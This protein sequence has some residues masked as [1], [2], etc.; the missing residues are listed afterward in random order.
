MRHFVLTCD[1]V[2]VKRDER[3]QIQSVGL[4]RAHEL[5]AK[6]AANE[7]KFIL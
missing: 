6:T 3:S 2:R 4:A 1:R 7:A 5:R